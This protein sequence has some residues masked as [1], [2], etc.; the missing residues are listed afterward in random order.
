MKP[1]GLYIHVPFCLK[2][3]N[4]CDFASVAGRMELLPAY[5]HALETELVLRRSDWPDREVMTIFLG[6]GTPSLLPPEAYGRLMETVRSTFAVHPDAE[7]SLEANPGTVTV[8]KAAAMRAAGFNRVSM[9]VQAAQDELLASLGRIHRRRD[10][11]EAAALYA[12]AGFRNLNVDL[13]FGLPGQTMEMW[14]ET[15]TFGLSLPVSHLSCYSLSIEEGTPWGELYRIKQ[16]EPASEELDRRMYHEMRNRLEASGFGQYELSNF[17][18]PGFSCRHNLIYWNRH[19][20]LGIGAGAHSLM[21]ETRFA[22]I[23]SPDAYIQGMETGIPLM[24]EESVL[25]PEEALSERMFM[26][27]RLTGGLRLD[28]VSKEFGLDVSARYAGEIHRLIEQGLVK[29][30][31]PLLR[32]TEKGLDLANQVFLAFL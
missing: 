3:C 27:M 4:Y 1:I 13:M 16:L 12:D 8:E 18:K 23:S 7:I 29:A 22:N 26:G 17:A 9:G 24:S 5:L 2:K 30:E 19:E 25:T 32:L 20:Y 15:L 11:E 21:G 14:R 31:G 10:A 28:W 6:G